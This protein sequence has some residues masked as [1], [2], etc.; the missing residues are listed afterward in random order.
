MT[1]DEMNFWRSGEW[2][3]VEERLDDMD[4]LGILYN[5]MRQDLFKALDATP[6]D[7]VKVLIMGQDPYPD[8]HLATGVA[9]DI[10]ADIHEHPMTLHNVLQEYS[11][12]LGLP[13][14]Q[15]G[16]LKTWTQEG[17]L[18]WNAIPSCTNGKSLS[19]DWNEWACL[20]REICNELS[21]KGIVAVLCGAVA[22]RF[23]NDFDDTNEIICTSHPSPRGVKFGKIPFIGSRVFSTVNVK[24]IEL[25][26]STVDWKLRRDL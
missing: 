14:P 9:F 24:L 25:G 20:T 2:Q 15:S 23:K 11:D 26:Y 6:Y 5:P 7:K 18:L 17:V 10:P 13:Y 22:Q 1:W 12:D 4:K 8:R 3:V 21:K 16:C 19:H